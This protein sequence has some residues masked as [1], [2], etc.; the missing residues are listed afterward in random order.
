VCQPALSSDDSRVHSTE[1]LQAVLKSLECT[2]EGMSQ[3]KVTSYGNRCHEN[4]QVS[5][6]VAAT[7]CT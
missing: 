4:S 3:G 1:G 6:C 5:C 2:M 7:W